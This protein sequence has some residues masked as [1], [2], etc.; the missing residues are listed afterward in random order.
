[1]A[2][3]AARGQRVALP[4][5][6]PQAMAE[7]YHKTH[8]VYDATKA[9]Y[10][11]PEQQVLTFR[12]IKERTDRPPARG[13]RGQ[14][15]VCRACPAFG[16]CTTDPRQGRA[17]AVGP[18]ETAVQEHRQGMATAEAKTMYRQRKELIEPVFGVVKE[19]LDGRHFLLRGLAKVQAEW[20]V[21]A[22]AFN[23]PT[24]VRRWQRDR[25]AA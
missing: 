7:P 13:Y 10:P 15:A 22:T 5:A 21:L 18:H 20:T 8:C 25:V 24:C 4:A 2:A 12:G 16:G 3:G 1:M 19:E 6:P 9:T 11:C 14:A 23:R 17:V